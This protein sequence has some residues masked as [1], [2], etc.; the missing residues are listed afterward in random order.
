[1]TDLYRIKEQRDAAPIEC[2]VI[3]RGTTMN[4]F[5]QHIPSFVDH[6]GE[7]PAADFETTEELLN[8]EV[9]KRYI[10]E[11]FSHFALSDN[12]LMAVSDDGFK[13]WVVGFIKNAGDIDL[14]Q[15]EGWK[16]RAELPNGN[17]VVLGSDVVSSYG[18]VLTLKDGTTA[19]N[20]GY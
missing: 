18:D 10:H 19:K 1:M 13:H 11:D 17:K 9:V 5:V 14:P 16:F 3:N 20:L 2:V 12:C 4:K 15:W 6:R 8:L 7:T